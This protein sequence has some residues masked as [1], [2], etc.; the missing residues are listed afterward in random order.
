MVALGIALL[1]AIAVWADLPERSGDGEAD[2]AFGLLTYGLCAE[3]H[4]LEPGVHLSGPSLAGI[5]G[6]PAGT[7]QG[8]GRYSKALRD[9]GLVWDEATLDAWLMDGKA[10]VPG[11][12]MIFAGMTGGR[13]RAGL[14]AL[15]RQLSRLGPESALARKAA[16]LTKRKRD[17]KQARPAFLVAKITYCADTYEVTTRSGSV[18][19]FWEYGFRIKTDRSTL[20]PRP[21]A[22]VLV[23]SGTV[24]DRAY[25]VF[26]APE[27]IGPAITR[28]CP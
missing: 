25:V 14:I 4:S 7:G 28:S 5:W 9:S 18:H 22:P 12:R 2:V 13:P 3:C 27:E 19:Q 26:A 17:L 1:V 6:R 8:F 15:F 23:P 10:L 16:G 21:G 24:G 20:G 11:N